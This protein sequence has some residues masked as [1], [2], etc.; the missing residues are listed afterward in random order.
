[1]PGNAALR[2]SRGKFKPS[3][4]HAN[5]RC[6][7]CHMISYLCCCRYLCRIVQLLGWYEFR[8]DFVRLGWGKK[9]LRGCE[10]H[11]PPP[12]KSTTTATTHP[13]TDMA[14]SSANALQEPI[15]APETSVGKPVASPAA[16]MPMVRTLP[17]ALLTAH[18]PPLLQTLEVLKHEVDPGTR[19]GEGGIARVFQGK[20]W[21]PPLMQANITQ[22][23]R[24]LH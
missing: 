11:P 6:A 16:S 23:K 7:R 3:C 12:P 5:L 4:V 8:T 14:T 13:K 2:N 9:G 20:F 15:E 22:M 10:D 1:M 17:K 18:D 24:L 21:Y 19:R